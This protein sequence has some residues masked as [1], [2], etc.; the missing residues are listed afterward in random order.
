MSNLQS[1]VPFNTFSNGGGMTYEQKGSIV[2][3]P[4]LTAYHNPACLVN[5]ISLDLLQA[6]YHTKFDSEVGNAFLVQLDDNTSI[7]FQGFG[8]GLYFHNLNASFITCPYPYNLLNTVP[9]NKTFFSRREIEGAE[10]AR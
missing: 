10:Q 8:S 4:S 2:S 5:I 7:T 6:A 3:F 9:E 1:C